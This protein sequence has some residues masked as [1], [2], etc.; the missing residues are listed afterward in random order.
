MARRLADENGEEVAVEADHERARV[1]WYYYIG[2][3]TQQEI[4]EKLS[5]TRLRVNRIIGQV[6]TDGSVRV[7]ILM[8]LA[9]CVALEE[10]LKTRFGLAGARVVPSV[11]DP[12]EQQ[13]LIGEAA[14]AMLD[15]LLTDGE[16]FGVGWGTTLSAATRRVTPRR[17]SNGWVATLMGGLTR[18]SGT[19]T[20]EVSTAFARVLGAECYYLAAPI[21]VPT[22]ESREVLLTHHG[23]AEALRRAR[24]AQVALVSC[25]DLSNRS[26]L[27]TTHVVAESL[28]DLR[29]ANAVGD[30]LGVFLDAEGRPVDHPLNER[31]MALPLGDLKTIPKAILASGGL[32]KRAIVKAILTAGYVKYLVTDE[33]CA[34]AIL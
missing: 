15:T 34:E 18:G 22:P 24:L 11:D 23:L 27:A 26:L 2:G 14:G 6:R 21:Y 5:I 10:D 7:E 33:A 19:N 9:R 3:L 17:L 12:A 25:G 8:P 4:A 20:F 1:A 13:R 28:D 31:V 29:A 32:H 16:A 30:I